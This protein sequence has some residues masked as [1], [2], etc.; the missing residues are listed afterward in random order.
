MQ[1]TST[2]PSAT[3]LHIGAAQSSPRSQLVVNIL[4]TVYDPN[5]VRLQAKTQQ[6]VDWEFG[7]WLLTN[8]D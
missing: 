7:D 5:G 8:Q 1:V 6:T 2:A 4:R 3:N